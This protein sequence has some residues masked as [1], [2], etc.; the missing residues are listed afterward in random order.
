MQARHTGCTVGRPSDDR[1]RQRPDAEDDDWGP[2][3]NT[4]CPS[5]VDWWF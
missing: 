3:V 4:V 1:G 2:L 5:W